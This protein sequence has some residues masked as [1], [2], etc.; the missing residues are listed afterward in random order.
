MPQV[1]GL[2]PVLKKE[3]ENKYFSNHLV[4]GERIIITDF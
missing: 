3:K 1:T 4:A 2:K